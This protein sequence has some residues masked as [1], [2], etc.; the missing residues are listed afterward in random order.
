VGRLKTSNPDIVLSVLDLASVR[1]GGSIAESFRNTV[2]LAQK[3]EDWG[4]RRFWLAEHHNI[5]GIA[6][7]AT[8]VLIGHVAGAT[9]SIR[10]GSGGIMLPN[11][12]P[13][14]IAEQFGTLEILYPHRID[15]GLGRAPGSDPLTAQALG[16][17]P[18]AGDRFPQMVQQLLHYLGPVSTGQ[19]IQAVPGADTNVPVWLL[20][21]STFSAQLA[22]AL[23]LPFA[24]AGQFAPQLMFEAFSLYRENFKPSSVLDKPYAMLGLPVLAADT[25]ELAQHL[26][27]SA[28]QRVLRLIRGQPI[29]TPPPVKNMDD[30]W[31]LA[32]RQ[33]VENHLGAAVI[34]GPATV[35]RK[36]RKLLE[37]TRADE[38]MLHTDCYRPED[39]LHS[40]EIVAKL[41]LTQLT[42]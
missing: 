34:G 18:R 2:T 9:K 13:L 25:D 40:Y 37:V 15:L 23:G 7:A 22:A 11:H 39:R 20:G 3:A 26:A 31:N 16:R 27:T 32:E 30:L 1:E 4:Y 24:F 12:S 42:T 41:F 28:Q 29:H 19:H 36:L 14:V 5:S 17:D 35:E 33:A 10:V 38:L 21:S 8:A 6:S